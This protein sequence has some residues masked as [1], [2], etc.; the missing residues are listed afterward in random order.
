MIL[1]HAGKLGD[2]F[3]SLII[4]NHYYKNENEKT[5][6]ILSN[7][8]KSIVGLEEFLMNAGKEKCE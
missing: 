6:F 8:F 4:S 1:T 3:P 5:T 2:F 7:W